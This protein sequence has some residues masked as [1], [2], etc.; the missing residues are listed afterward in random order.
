MSSACI[1]CGRPLRPEPAD[2]SASARARLYGPECQRQIDAAIR[3]LNTTT[4]CP[5]SARAAARLLATGA[6]QRSGS[7]PHVYSTRSENPATPNIVYL[8]TPTRCTCPAAEHRPSLPT[9]KHLLA[10]VVLE[11]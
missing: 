9:C 1:K 7:A 3:I 2:A 6:T 10:V 4:T 8:T 5:V 11:A